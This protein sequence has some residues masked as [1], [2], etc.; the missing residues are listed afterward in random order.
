MRVFFAPSW[1]KYRKT[2]I[3][4][5]NICHRQTT[6]LRFERFPANLTRLREEKLF[7]IH[8]SGSTPYSGVVH[9]KYSP[10]IISFDFLSRTYDT[11]PDV[12]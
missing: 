5:C 11:Q 3:F 1:K 9:E 6:N 2:R 8:Q 4:V 12:G 10:P 7:R